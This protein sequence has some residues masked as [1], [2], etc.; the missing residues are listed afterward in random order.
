MTRP[1]ISTSDFLGLTVTRI[2][3]AQIPAG[4][5][6]TLDES[7]QV[8]NLTLNIGGR[9]ITSFH[10]RD[11]VEVAMNY[12]LKQDENPKQVI[13][14]YISDNGSLE[15][16]KNGKYDDTSGKVIFKP[17][18]FSLYA[19][20]YSPVSFSDLSTSGWASDAVKALAAREVINGY[21]DGSFRPTD[22]VTRA[23]FISLLMNA[24]DLTDLNAVS[25]FS[26]VKVNAWYT[27]SIASAEK[28]GIVNGKTD[29]IFGVTD[30]ITRQ[31][32]AV[33]A[34]RVSK[35]LGLKLNSGP[36][37]ADTFVDQSQ[38]ANFATDAVTALQ[39]AGFISGLGAGRFGPNLSSTRTEAAVLIYNLFEQSI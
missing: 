31:E 23:E 32:M 11:Q 13:V 17:A 10:P 37:G 21:M 4:V 36:T 35:Q 9:S 33:M 8:Y 19:A 25:N 29:G 34:Y 14:Y 38:I 26:D 30:T 15:V 18:R 6:E 22:A 16:V 24:F 7:V 28:L 12:K 39:Q 1:S 3:L 27:S 2:D 5:L 20:A